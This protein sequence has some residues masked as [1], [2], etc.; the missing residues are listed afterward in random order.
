MAAAEKENDETVVFK[1]VV[2]YYKPGTTNPFASENSTVTCDVKKFALFGD[3]KRYLDEYCGLEGQVP[4]LTNNKFT[5]YKISL[6]RI[7]TN[8]DTKRFETFSIHN[9]MQWDTE[10]VL[11]LKNKD[12]LRGK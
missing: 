9:Q 12:T 11:L 1:A 2:A 6:V 4:L 8:P 3:I 5:K 7:G 10:R